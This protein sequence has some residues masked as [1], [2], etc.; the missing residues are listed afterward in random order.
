MARTG[1]EV[2]GHGDGGGRQ[3]R[4][5]RVGRAVKVGPAQLVGREGNGGFGVGHAQQRLGQAHQG[6]ALGA[7]DGVFLEQAFHG[8]ERRRVVAHRAHP[9]RGQVGGSG[10]VQRALQGGQALG[11]GG[12]L[13][14]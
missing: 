8:P 11:H 7:G 5:R 12:G 3:T 13:G 4:Q 2:L 6:Q 10:P 14:R 1:Q 9:G